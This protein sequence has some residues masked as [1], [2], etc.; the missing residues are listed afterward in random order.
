M[1]VTRLGLRRLATGLAAAGGLLLAIA[2][3]L[4]LAEGVAVDGL[5]NSLFW[6]PPGLDWIVL[7]AAAV[8]V[9]VALALWDSRSRARL[10]GPGVLVLAGAATALLATSLAASDTFHRCNWGSHPY[11][12][13]ARGS[14]RGCSETGR[15]EPAQALGAATLGGT[16][17]IAAGLLLPLS[18]RYAPA[19]SELRR[20]RLR[21]FS[22]M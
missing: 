8:V 18:T 20:R 14:M 2:P 16:L 9:P 13:V 12:G 10:A 19:E 6:R 1:G 7:L 21:S 3:F 4:P 17:L 15:Y 22:Y 11:G 5:R